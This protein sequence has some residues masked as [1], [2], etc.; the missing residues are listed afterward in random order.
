LLHGSRP[1]RIGGGN[2]FDRS[3][4]YK[5]AGDGLTL[6]QIQNGSS[7]QETLHQLFVELTFEALI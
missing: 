4:C 7:V 2:G 3:A 6:F 1:W 5:T